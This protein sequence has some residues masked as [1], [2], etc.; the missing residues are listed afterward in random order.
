MGQHSQRL[1]CSESKSRGEIEG[2]CGAHSRAAHLISYRRLGVH[3]LPI[4]TSIWDEYTRRQTACTELFRVVRRTI[5]QRCNRSR[6][7]GSRTDV[8]SDQEDAEG[9]PSIAQQ[10]PEGVARLTG[11]AGEGNMKSSRVIAGEKSSSS[12]TEDGS[13]SSQPVHADGLTVT[14]AERSVVISE[15]SVSRFAEHADGLPR[16]GLDSHSSGQVIT[17]KRLLT[18][19]TMKAEPAESEKSAIRLDEF[20]LLLKTSETRAQS[21]IRTSPRDLRTKKTSWAPYQISH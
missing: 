7:S 3:D 5:T 9:L 11:V 4:Q 6:N 20:G 16:S 15:T 14:V 19:I 2:G 21:L 18:K 8:A 12:V 13:E 17:R 10:D 1:A